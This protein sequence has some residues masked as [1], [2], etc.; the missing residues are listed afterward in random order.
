MNGALGLGRYVAGA[1]SALSPA[2]ALGLTLA[3]I[4]GGVGVA[5]AASSAFVLGRSNS[6]FGTATL[7]NSRGTPLALVA[8]KNTAP[9]SVSQQA[10]VANLNAQFVG[11]LNAS[12][13]SAT[14]G[15]GFIHPGADI[16]LSGD[17]VTSVVSTGKLPAGSYY[18][19]ASALI[20]VTPGDVGGF[21]QIQRADNGALFARG[22]GG[23]IGFVQAFETAAVQLKSPGMLQEACIM[24]GSIQG[25]EVVD[26]GITA[27]RIG[28]YHGKAPQINGIGVSISR[29]Q[30]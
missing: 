18:V 22:G 2:A 8:P 13:A 30:R 10:A 11:G 28:A 5:D 3:V 24:K 4:F 7:T 15:D 1:V 27:V 14:G 23:A 25:T 12:A 20:A 29:R 19:S 17:V 9:L 26:A 16:P 6:E 21:C